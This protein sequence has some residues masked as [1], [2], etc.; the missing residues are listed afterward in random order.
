MLFFTTFFSLFSK[1]RR[2]CGDCLSLPGRCAWCE[3]TQSCFVFSTY[4]TYF[5]YGACREW[6]D[7]DHVVLNRYTNDSNII[8]AKCRDCSLHETCKSC[9]EDLSCGWCGNRRNPYHGVCVR[10]DFKHSY[11]GMYLE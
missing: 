1:R 5:Q 8:A 10:G 7:E 4:T 2:S 11:E 6:V 9:L 3:Q